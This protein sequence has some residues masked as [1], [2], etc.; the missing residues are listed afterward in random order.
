MWGA[1]AKNCS[2]PENRDASISLCTCTASAHIFSTVFDRFRAPRSIDASAS[3]DSAWK[4]LHSIFLGK[5][6]ARKQKKK[7]GP[8]KPR[9]ID[10]FMQMYCMRSHFLVRFRSFSITAIDGCTGIADS[11]SKNLHSIP[12]GKYTARKQK[13][14]R[15]PKTAMHRFL[16]ASVLHALTFFRAFSIVFEHND[17][18]TH[19]HRSIR[20]GKNYIR[21]F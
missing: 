18:S 9:C 17:R 14:V 15:A 21:F 13:I 10:F 20:H 3:L 12:V 1:Q 11:A 6:T 8:R 16:Y 5:Y 7:F 19:R 2:G 4:K